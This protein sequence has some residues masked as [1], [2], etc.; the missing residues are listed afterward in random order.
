MEQN[1]HRG[2]IFWVDHP[3]QGVGSEMKKVRPAVVVSNEKNNLF[4]PNI[5]ICYLTTAEK[6]KHL[7]THM[8]IML[9]G[10]KN[11]VLCENVYTIA[12]D[13]LGNYIASLGR[14]EQAL[15]DRALLISLGLPS[16]ENFPQTQKSVQS[17][18]YPENAEELE[19]VKKR[20]IELQAQ[21]Q[22]YHQLLSSFVPNLGGTA[23]C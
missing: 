1:I 8:E 22:L 23:P 13:R 16:M 5:E 10:T 15:V 12:K 20:C 6:K 21:N 3:Q 4:S 7:P 9:I 17:V 19:S 14:D 2:D 18:Q 11:T